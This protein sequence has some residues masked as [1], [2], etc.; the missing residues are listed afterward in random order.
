MVSTPT[1]SGRGEGTTCLQCLRHRHAVSR[2][3]RVRGPDAKLEVDLGVGLA[4]KGDAKGIQ[5]FLLP[6]VR[7]RW[8]QGI[9]HVC[10]CE[11]LSDGGRRG[12]AAGQKR[13]PREEG[14][15]RE[16]IPRLDGARTGYRDTA[17]GATVWEGVLWTCGGRYRH[18]ESAV[19]S[20]LVD[21]QDG[22][23]CDFGCRV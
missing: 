14:D 20:R 13:R 22:G 2:L 10:F 7:S 18:S 21:G 1:I 9:G 3:P 17:D 15:V 12:Q 16:G 19:A 4:N 8:H 6:R 23:R 5:S 11:C